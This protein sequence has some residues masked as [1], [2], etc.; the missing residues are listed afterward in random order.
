MNLTPL[1]L[2]SSTQSNESTL[3]LITRKLSHDLDEIRHRSLD[4]LESK[5]DNN[6]VSED[7]V[8]HN[9]ELLVKLL[10]ILESP[11]L[12]RHHEKAIRI[13][14]KL[15]RWTSTAQTLIKLNGLEILE[16]IRVDTTN[17]SMMRDDLDALIQHLTEQL[18]EWS[19]STDRSN[20]FSM[21][22]SID[23]SDRLATLSIKSQHNSS[24][25]DT[26]RTFYY[27][28]SKSEKLDIVSLSSRNGSIKKNVIKI[29]TLI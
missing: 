28:S 9:R 27:D 12:N 1:E 14:G 10:D 24:A 11:K 23:T 20:N 18:N 17:S 4:N 16:K 13:L 19:K 6:L 5:L 22:H 25:C 29:I 3:S 2:N 8:V 15:M 21:S 7:D 26:D